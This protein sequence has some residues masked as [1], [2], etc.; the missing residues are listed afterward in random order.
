[1]AWII[2]IL[3]GKPERVRRLPEFCGPIKPEFKPLPDMHQALLQES[4]RLNDEMRHC[5]EAS[6]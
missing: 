5:L 1:M 6:F 3:N 2:E 4:K